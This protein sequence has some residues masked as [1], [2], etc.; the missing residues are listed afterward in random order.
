MQHLWS[1]S[2][3]GERMEKEMATHSSILA[4]ETHGQRSLVTTVQGAAKESDMTL[5]TEQQQQ[6]GEKVSM[7]LLSHVSRVRLC[8]TP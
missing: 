8:A 7:L 4:W 6:Q 2:D 5:V 1:L 3:A